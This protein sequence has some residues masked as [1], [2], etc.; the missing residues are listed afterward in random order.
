M[1]SADYRKQ[2]TSR[3]IEQLEAGTASWVKP[4]N[5]DNVPVG[6]PHNAIKTRHYQGGNRLWL[7]C[8]GYADPRWC[9]F[10]QAAEQGWQVRRGERA[11]VV[12]YWMWE[13][14]EQDANGNRVRLKLDVP[15]VFYAHVFNASQMDG[16]FE[17]VPPVTLWQG[18]VQAETILN[19]SGARIIHD[20]RDAAFYAPKSD[21]IHLPPKLAF[22][23]AARYYATALHEL[24][25]WTGHPDRLNRD[26]AQKFGTAEYARE[27]LRAELASYFVS[28]SLG[29]AHDP[30]QH[31][32]YIGGWID[33]LRKDHNE[34]FRAAKDAEHISDY[35]LQFAKER[36]PEQVV[37]EECE[38]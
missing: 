31:A 8:Q 38:C 26:L 3:I 28:S 2:L 22:E 30:G 34:L 14:E 37:E 19:N 12:E 36:Q 18:D 13:K 20:Q 9:T 5:P 7:D 11:S 10:K 15:K 25:H 27:E 32:S 21:E 23:V 33:A 16:V 35:V 1:N 29:I 24:G 6:S 17:R 4:W